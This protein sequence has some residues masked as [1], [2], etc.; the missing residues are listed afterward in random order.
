MIVE[1]APNAW[2]DW[3]EFN[4]FDT[5]TLSPC[6]SQNRINIRCT[7]AHSLSCFYC[8]FFW[9]FRFIDVFRALRGVI[10]VPAQHIGGAAAKPLNWHRPQRKK[11][12][13]G[14]LSCFAFQASARRWNI[15]ESVAYLAKTNNN[16]LQ[17]RSLSAKRLHRTCKVKIIGIEGHAKMGKVWNLW[18]RI[19]F[20][21]TRAWCTL[22]PVNEC[23]KSSYINQ[24][25]V[26]KTPFIKWRE[27]FC[28]HS[29]H[30]TTCVRTT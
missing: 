18:Y 3:F 23:T 21:D 11:T 15:L 13:S 19:N 25:L 12:I 4:R 2:S 17:T 28:R 7:A 22:Q 9:S 8:C 20:N 24:I 14:K 10:F 6:L 5:R 26:S 29:L 30:S 27:F 16:H 1:K